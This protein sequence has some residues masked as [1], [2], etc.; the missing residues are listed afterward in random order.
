MF[1]VLNVNYSSLWLNLI[2]KNYASIT[3][4]NYLGVFGV[5]FWFVYFR[6]GAGG[7]GVGC[8]LSIIDIKNQKSLT[9]KFTVKKIN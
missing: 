5:F 9:S 2:K 6:S 8:Q 4:F 7:G 1:Y 3:D